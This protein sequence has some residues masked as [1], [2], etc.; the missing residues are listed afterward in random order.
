MAPRDFNDIGR[1]L[2]HCAS[3]PDRTA[4]VFG[5]RRISYGE[6][7]RE[8]RRVAGLFA[9]VP[10]KRGDRVLM[11]AG[12]TPEYLINYFAVVEAGA[13]FIPLHIDLAPHEIAYIAKHAEP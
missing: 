13:V 5:E 1:L 11:M 8:I 2:A 12:N 7:I 9:R 4:I 10:V 6:L 3:E